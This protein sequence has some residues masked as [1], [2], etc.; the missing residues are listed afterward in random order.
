MSLADRAE[1]SAQS[2]EPFLHYLCCQVGSQDRRHCVEEAQEVL[3]ELLC[4]FTP[5]LKAGS[6][7][8]LL[9]GK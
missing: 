5:L 9:M 8:N 6:H 2:N 3:F 4:H 7:I 1:S